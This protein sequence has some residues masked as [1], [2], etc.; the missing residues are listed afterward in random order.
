[1]TQT[2][3][4]WRRFCWLAIFPVTT[5]IALS[6]L[7]YSNKLHWGHFW[8]TLTLVC[9]T[10]RKEMMENRLLKTDM[11]KSVLEETDCELCLQHPIF[12]FFVNKK[13]LFFSTYLHLSSLVSALTKDCVFRI[14]ICVWEKT[15]QCKER[16]FSNFQLEYLKLKFILLI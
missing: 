4:E 1:M 6:A 7:T 12:G 8:N 16:A 3:A 11:F 15:K 9:V 10:G 5:T 2:F 14:S 13:K